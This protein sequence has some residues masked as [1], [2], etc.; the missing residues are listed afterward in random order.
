MLQEKLDG[1]VKNLQ[2]VE[3]MTSDD[4]SKDHE[5]KFKQRN[6]L[7]SCTNSLNKALRGVVDATEKGEIFWLERLAWCVVL[8]LY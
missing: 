2:Q 3:E 5:R 1:L 6:V 4:V 8:M 7:V